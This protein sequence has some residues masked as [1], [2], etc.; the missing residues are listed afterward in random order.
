MSSSSKGSNQGSN[1]SNQHSPPSP[2]SFDNLAGGALAERFEHV[3]KQVMQNM[4][5]PNTKATTIR[6]IALTISFKAD[7]EREIVDISHDVSAKLAPLKSYPTKGYLGIKDGMPVMYESADPKQMHMRDQLREEETRL[8]EAREAAREE[9]ARKEEA[10]RKGRE[11]GKVVS[12]P[13]REVTE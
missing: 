11:E 9:A 3:L 13:G 2:M 12:M 7:E 8:E 4:Y 10:E 5:D 6:K 1:Q